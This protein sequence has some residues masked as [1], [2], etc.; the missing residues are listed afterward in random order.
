MLTPFTRRTDEDNELDERKYV[1]ICSMSR[2]LYCRIW[3]KKYGRNANH[4][5]KEAEGQKHRYRNNGE[6]GGG[7]QRYA[8]SK[9]TDNEPRPSKPTVLH[10]RTLTN[11]N[12]TPL[13]PSWEAKR[14]LKE[15]Q[16]VGIAQPQGTKIKF[17]D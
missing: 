2:S 3:E 15:Q 11:I 5:K 12:D 4:K 16:R 9:I 7:S 8:K 14:K 10:P 6:Q 17:S 13:H 1:V